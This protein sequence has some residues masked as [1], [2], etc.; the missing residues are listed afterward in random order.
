MFYCKKIKTCSKLMDMN[1]QIEILK[2]QKDKDISKA[3]EIIDKR[4]KKILELKHEL[5]DIQRILSNTIDN[6]KLQNF[7][8]SKNYVDDLEIIRDDLKNE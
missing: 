2:H 1:T 6:W 5:K 3:L 8:N 7:S 4:N